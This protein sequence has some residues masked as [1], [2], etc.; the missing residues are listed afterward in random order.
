MCAA[1]DEDYIWNNLGSTQ[2]H[3]FTCLGKALKTV[4][5]EAK[6]PRSV[7]TC[8][9]KGQKSENVFSK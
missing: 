8:Q 7:A 2:T 3:K 5:A 6:I 9:H 4:K 1:L